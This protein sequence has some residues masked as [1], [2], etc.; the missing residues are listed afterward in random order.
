[1]EFRQRAIIGTSSSHAL[2]PSSRWGGT[3]NRF[4]PDCWMQGGPNWP[5]VTSRTSW[6]LQKSAKSWAGSAGSRS[7]A[8]TRRMPAAAMRDRSP[9]PVLAWQ[10]PPRAVEALHSNVDI[11]NGSQDPPPGPTQAAFPTPSEPSTA[12]PG[13]SAPNFSLPG[14][15]HSLPSLILRQVSSF[16]RFL[17]SQITAGNAPA[18]TSSTWPMPLPFP[19][20]SQPGAARRNSWRHKRINLIVALLN[21]FNLGC[22]AAAPAEIQRDVP[23]S[24]SAERLGLLSASLKIAL[25]FS[26]L[27]PSLWAGPP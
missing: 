20:V 19:A 26:S 10:L 15:W 11:D 21:W 16:S 2:V 23:L 17:R 27:T 25:R 9:R 3:R 13:A 4:T 24:D 14:F 1:M 22:R 5:W 7:K 18:H 6:T 8:R 12:V